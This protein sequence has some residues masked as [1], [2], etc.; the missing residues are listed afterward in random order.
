MGEQEADNLQG[1]ARQAV[2]EL[3]AA[4][5]RVPSDAGEQMTGEL[6]RARH[7]A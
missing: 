7:I 6:L 4:L 5:V 3:G 2:A 1:M